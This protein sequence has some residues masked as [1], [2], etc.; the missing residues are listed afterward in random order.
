MTCKHNWEVRT[1]GPCPGESVS[2]CAKCSSFRKEI[3]EP[4]KVVF[5]YYTYHAYEVGGEPYCVIS[6]ENVNETN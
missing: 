5:E 4:I 2:M 6:C 3:V 1:T